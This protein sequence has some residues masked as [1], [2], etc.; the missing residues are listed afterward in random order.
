M[1]NMQ[2]FYTCDKNIPMRSTTTT[3]LLTFIL[4]L[5]SCGSQEI[6]PGVYVTD[7]PSALP[8]PT[9]GYRIYIVGEAHGNR[10]TKLLFISYLERL[11][12]QA[13]LRDVILEED[14]A[15]EGAANAYVLGGQ[16]ALAPELCLRHDVLTYIR[17]FN[18]AQVD[19]EKIKVH[20]VDVDSPLSAI[21]LHLR[22]L[23]ERIG[24]AA[25]EISI[26]G[27][28]EFETWSPAQ[29]YALVDALGSVAADDASVLNGLQT[30]HDSIRWYWLG[31]RIETGPA[32]GNR[33]VFAPIRED[34]I[35]NNIQFLVG[36]SEVP[37]LVFY[38]SA[39]GMKLQA[40][41]YPPIRG[42]T[43]WAQRILESGIP[44]YSLDTYPMA[45]AYF[46]RGSEYPYESNGALTLLPD[47]TDLG[48]LLLGQDKT[49]L[50]IDYR[51]GDNAASTL[52]TG[53]ADIPA[54]QVYDGQVLFRE[55][56]PMN[57]AC[58]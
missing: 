39:H 17:D 48:Q 7:D 36:N 26:P 38:G 58:Q 40:D 21:H 30:I 16:T 34:I 22:S 32:T 18:A 20:L 44:V 1:I 46:W 55:V 41:P 19:D 53:Y 50:Y 27:Q 24:P 28:A 9:S 35:T 6:R 12:E 2:G 14:Q 31:N 51:V 33:M 49:I 5:T 10:E 47:G 13:G 52:P 43:S 3:I 4:L 57:D 37:Y 8:L 25:G 29:M 15:Y 42:F 23:H 45:G 11:Q 56:T 54:G